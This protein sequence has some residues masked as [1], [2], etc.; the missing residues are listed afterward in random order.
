MGF[1]LNRVGSWRWLCGFVHRYLFGFSSSLG[2]VPN[3]FV[4]VMLVLGNEGGS[5]HHMH[6]CHTRGLRIG[7]RSIVVLTLYIH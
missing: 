3:C 5:P 1:Q 2:L 7:L 4:L 6:D